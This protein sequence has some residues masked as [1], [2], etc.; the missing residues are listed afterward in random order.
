M[1]HIFLLFFT[2]AIISCSSSSSA[3]TTMPTFTQTPTI[4]P[5][6]STPT[7]SQT[8]TPTPPPTPS[9]RLLFTWYRGID[10]DSP[11]WNRGYRDNFP[12]ISG[13]TNIFISYLDGTDITPITIDGLDGYS[14]V[15]DISPDGQKFLVASFSSNVT[16]APQTYGT[17]Y[18]INFEG[19]TS[20]K[21]VGYLSHPADGLDHTGMARWVNNTQIVYTGLYSGKN[22]IFLI[23]EDGTDISP[24]SVDGIPHKIYGFNPENG[25]IVWRAKESHFGGV[26]WEDFLRWSSIDGT[27]QEIIGQGIL[28]GGISMTPDGKFLTWGTNHPKYTSSISDLSNPIPVNPPNYQEGGFNLFISP[29][30]SAIFL[31]QYNIWDQ[32]KYKDPNSR[33]THYMFYLG[34]NSMKEFSFPKHPEGKFEY[35]EDVTWSPNGQYALLRDNLLD[36]RR[37]V[38][39]QPIR[40]IDLETLNFFAN[41]EDYLP[42]RKSNF[43]WISSP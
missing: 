10:V 30:N 42:G 37:Y 6:K 26:G 11:L 24:I 25:G 36:S 8:F 34:G 29:T 39:S 22:G 2:F 20:N 9:G 3:P 38:I 5:T 16:L 19:Y 17:L 7:A 35:I 15:Q 12:D 40:I 14:F 41:L 18:M 13:D 31:S 21:I 28:K 32:E 1:K 33:Y 4:I 27:E 43:F 23:N